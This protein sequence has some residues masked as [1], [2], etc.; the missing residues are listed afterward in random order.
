M[1]GSYLLD[2]N[3]CIALLDNPESLS[4]QVIGATIFVPCIVVGELIFGAKKSGK[5]EYNLIRYQKFIADNTILDCDK[6]TGIIYGEIKSKLEKKGRPIPENDI[7][8]AAIALQ[9]DLIVISRD[10]H[11]ENIEGLEIERW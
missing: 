8:I 6:E 1:N 3:I 9:N 11:F 2:T 5:V 10:Q 4:Q 7:W